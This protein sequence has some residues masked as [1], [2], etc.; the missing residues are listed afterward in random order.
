VPGSIGIQP[1]SRLRDLLPRVRALRA[2]PC[3]AVRPED[4]ERARRILR[5][6]GLLASGLKA[7]MLGDLVAFPVID[8]GDAARILGEEGVEARPCEG[9][10]EEYKRPGRLSEEFPGVSSYYIV[11]EA[12]IINERP[13]V[14]REVLVEAAKRILETHPRVRGVY[15]KRGVGGEYRVANLELLAGERVGVTVHKEYGL[16]FL[17][18]V[19][20]VYVNPSLAPEHRRVAEQARDG[21]LVLD[22]FSGYGAFAIHVA[23]LHDSTVVSVDVNPH[24]SRLAVENVAR[25]RRRLRGRVAVLHADAH[26]L[27][28]ILA[29]VFNRIIMNH[30]TA[31]TG[32]AGEACRLVAGRAW[33]HFYILAADPG[34]AW[35]RAREAFKAAGCRASLEASREVVEYSPR[36]SIYALDLVVSRA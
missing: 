20:K 4:A 12:A 8:A 24:A 16:E 32:F 31:S 1:I 36:L 19:E 3:V 11:G 15:L 14:P 23:H 30:P 26:W 2:S 34:E 29:P 27:P 7:S 25:N 21:E 6:R 22:M 18:D 35:G 9:F 13:G 17:V 28:G 10:F 33:V 5:S